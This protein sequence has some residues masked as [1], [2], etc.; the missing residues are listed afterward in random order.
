VTDDGA[1]A[2]AIARGSTFRRSEDMILRNE[3]LLILMALWFVCFAL[4]VREVF[5]TGLSEPIT[6]VVGQSNSYPVIAG[7]DLDRGSDPSGLELGDRVLRV[8]GADLRGAGFIAFEALAIEQANGRPSVSLLYER[9]GE[10]RTT[11][12]A[13]VPAPIAWARIPAQ[14]AT[15]LVSVLILIRAPDRRQAR[16]LFAAMLGMLFHQTPF[17]GGSFVQTQ[18]SEWIFMSSGAVAAPLVLYW[19]A[20]FPDGGYA[21]R[22]RR[23]G[24]PW[25]FG[26]AYAALRLSFVL[27]GP[28]SPP[29]IPVAILLTDTCMLVTALVSITLNYRHSTSVGRRKIKWF[30]YGTYFSTAPL[31]ANSLSRILI[32]DLPWADLMFGLSVGCTVA[33]PLGLLVATI[34]YDLFDIDRLISATASYSI[35]VIGFIASGL[36]LSRYVIDT[37]SSLFGTDPLFVQIGIYVALAAAFAPV[38]RW[39]KP[40]LDGVFFPERHALSTGIETLLTDLSKPERSEEALDRLGEGI[41]NLVRPVSCTVY[42]LSDTHYS[43]VFSIGNAST[44]QF[45]R[46][47]P[48]VASVFE[49]ATLI[50]DPK[51]TERRRAA[52]LS[53]YDRASL[54]TLS[55]AIVL[56]VRRGGQPAAFVAL[57]PKRSGDIYTNTDLSALTSAAQQ[58]ETVLTHTENPVRHNEAVDLIASAAPSVVVVENAGRF[59]SG[60]VVAPGVIL[61]SL[62]LVGPATQLQIRLDDGR[63]LSAEVASGC[64]T[65]DLA[66]LR[67]NLRQLPSLR[68][69]RSRR[70]KLGEPLVAIGCPGSMFGPLEQSI[71]KGVVSGLRSLPSPSGNGIP[72]RYV[73][74]DTALNRG[75]SGGPL[76]N[77]WGEVIGINALK[78]VDS[79]RE[80]LS[81]AVAIEEAIEAF[82]ILRDAVG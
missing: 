51:K 17:K 59:G 81:F 78:D 66:L 30:L 33:M 80:G 55:A 57:G 20:I 11:E 36:W 5:R 69:G 65:A 54:A 26:I 8:G 60:F 52:E 68:L 16:W 13:L 25:I 31:V 29:A 73:Q 47:S 6:Y 70:L 63:L 10:Q 15:A 22:I 2:S 37:V 71:S 77:Q 56:P 35:V 9:D 34:R 72:V 7:F 75:N 49:R 14:L 76:L 79:S 1:R 18:T 46:G 24:V 4:H 23:I 44:S 50:A 62:H 21:S 32:P 61:T 64:E 27:G 82:P 39:L 12:L 38:S 74:T 53:D 3:P 28:V 19:I 45:D 58:V 40:L 41:A 42:Q 67:T 43:P 48:V